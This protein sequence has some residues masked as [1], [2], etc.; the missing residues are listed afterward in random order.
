M[1]TLQPARQPPVPRSEK[2][3]PPI[4]PPA[5]KKHS[6]FST[7]ARRCATPHHRPQNFRNVSMLHTHP[8]QIVLAHPM[9]PTSTVSTSM[10]TSFSTR[11]TIAPATARAS[12]SPYSGP[13]SP[14]PPRSFSPWMQQSQAPVS[15]SASP[16]AT[17]T[18]S[19]SF[20]FAPSAFTS[21]FANCSSISPRE[22]E[23][24]SYR[25]R[26]QRINA[27]FNNTRPQSQ[28]RHHARTLRTPAQRELLARTQPS[29]KPQ[30]DEVAWLLEQQRKERMVN[31]E[32]TGAHTH[33]HTHTRDRSPNLVHCCP[34][35]K[36]RI[37]LSNKF[38]HSRRVYNGKGTY[39]LQNLIFSTSVS[40]L[41]PDNE[42][43]CGKQCACSVGPCGRHGTLATR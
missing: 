1:Q 9:T 39:G 34:S 36:F 8:Q 15:S 23:H 27:H 37:K 21:S 18:V 22:L 5:H 11:G 24:S 43:M 7:D 3:P 20:S 38:A 12:T 40:V 25:T 10:S 19:S 2:D 29:T 42:G 17:N 16:S 35:I 31:Y 14:R 26:T 32:S 4:P 30:R 13:R 33:T 41:P 6:I 28:S